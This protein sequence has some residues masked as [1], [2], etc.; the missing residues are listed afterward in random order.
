MAPGE[1]KYFDIWFGS[2]CRWFFYAITGVSTSY[3]VG[4]ASSICQNSSVSPGTLSYKSFGFEYI[5]YVDNQ[6]ITKRQIGK[7][8]IV[9]CREP[10]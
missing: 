1:E 2:P 8:L 5:E 3:T 7:D 6:Q 10:H 4:G 9:K